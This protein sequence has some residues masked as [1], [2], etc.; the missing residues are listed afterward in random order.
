MKRLVINREMAALAYI[1]TPE[2]WE[3]YYRHN[4]YFYVNNET[5][6]K[7]FRNDGAEK[8]ME[9]ILKT[10]RKSNLNK[11]LAKKV[12]TKK[13][14]LSEWGIRACSLNDIIRFMIFLNFDISLIQKICYEVSQKYNMDKKL[15][16]RVFRE[17]E[18][19]FSIRNYVRIDTNDS[20]DK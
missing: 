4:N 10:T 14:M 11:D 2:F 20:V 19:E 12:L 16:Y 3:T 1:Q 5:I 7:S 18:D 17:T 9:L 6:F 15:A 8:G 13:D